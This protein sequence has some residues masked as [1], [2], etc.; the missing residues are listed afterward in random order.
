M[1]FTVPAS[2]ALQLQIKA[3][4]INKWLE[5]KE[6]FPACVNQRLIASYRS[7]AM[8]SICSVDT[9][10]LCCFRFSLFFFSYFF[11]LLLPLLFSPP[12]SS[13]P[14]CFT[15]ETPLSANNKSTRSNCCS[16]PTF[17]ESFPFGGTFQFR[18][19]SKMIFYSLPF[20]FHSHFLLRIDYRVIVNLMSNRQQIYDFIVS[21]IGS[22]KLS[23][24]SNCRW[25]TMITGDTV[26]IYTFLK[27]VNDD[28]R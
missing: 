7:A 3:R 21:L 18:A 25:Y 6:K 12:S 2:T 14:R 16:K 20:F 17:S 5:A 10:V 15:A 26:G 23:H 4:R 9:Y 11:F 8:S 27:T 24:S 22:S 28:N 13:L 19:E 1:A